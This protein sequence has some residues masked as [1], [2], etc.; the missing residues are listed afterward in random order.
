MGDNIAI[1]APQGT[2]DEYVWED[3]LNFIE[4][5]RVIPI[6]G[7]ELLQVETDTGQRPLYDWV[8][9]ELAERLRIDTT[10]L[11]PQYTLNDV[12]CCAPRREEAYARLRGI[13]KD[14]VFAPSQSL[15]QLAQ[16]TDFNL[17]ITTTFDSLLET[18][19]NE[20]RFKGQ[21]G[22]ESYAYAPNRVVDLPVEHEQLRQP[23]IYH[24]LGKLSAA[25]TYVISDDDMLEFVCALQSEHLVPEKLFHALEQNHLLFIGSNF[26]D[27]LARIFLRMVKRRRLSDPRDVGEV[28]ADTHSIA[29]ERLMGFLQ[30][31]SVRTRVYAGAEKFVAEL[32]CRWK[33][34]QREGLPTAAPIPCP[35]LI[36]PEREMPDK[37]VFIS[38]ARED[39]A[40][41][42]R[43]R[44]GLESA[45]VK[46]WFDMDRLEAGDDYNLKIQRNISRC[47]YFIPIVSG[48]TNRR[49]EGYFR[50]EWNWAIDRTMGMTDESRFI[51]PVAI[52]DTDITDAA[53]PAKFQALHFTRLQEG[54]VTAEF[55]G[56]L[57][58]QQ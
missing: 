44:S 5:N 17:Y 35:P 16:I 24:L 57:I 58:G 50:R 31:V 7:P 47:S 53:V 40:A 9:Q 30:Q 45:G 14:A 3:L 37:A 21:P 1:V 8:A 18:A 43:L 29:N 2:L 38:Y 51:L 20:E 10:H 41:V 23:V 39:L 26:S 34:R 46:V 42:G 33:A 28:L 15:R 48:S 36:P 6:I 25:P 11:P 32:H 22:V 12:V 49:R 4:E 19:L 54:V 52:D 13:F 55:V 56:K 27:W